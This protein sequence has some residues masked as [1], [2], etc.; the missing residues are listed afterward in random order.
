A[1]DLDGKRI[2]IL[3]PK[4]ATDAAMERPVRIET[5]DRGIYLDDG[6][7]A[8]RRIKVTSFGNPVEAGMVIGLVQFATGEEGFSPIGEPNRIVNHPDEVIAQAG[9]FVEFEVSAARPG[10]C[11]LQFVPDVDAADFNPT[12]A[13]FTNIRVLP[14]D[15]YSRLPD[16]SITWELVYR[17]VLQYYYC[18]YP[19]MDR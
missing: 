16:A 1:G 2:A 9:G 7:R 3:L 5:P 15:D 6:D 18:L 13:Y 10:L 14:K 4:Y 17:E 8:T 19:A 11:V 12:S